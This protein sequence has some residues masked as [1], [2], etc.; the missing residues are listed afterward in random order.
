MRTAAQSSKLTP[1]PCPSLAE[2]ES[3]QADESLRL[4]E[5]ERVAD[6]LIV[7]R[8]ANL[9]DRQEKADLFRLRE[10]GRSAEKVSVELGRKSAHEVEILSGL[11]A[12]DRVILADM[13]EWI[14]EPVIQIR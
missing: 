8:P 10:D 1:M 13:S 6:T 14:E 9:R 12:G 11:E 2:V 4:I 3:A 7:A 5:I